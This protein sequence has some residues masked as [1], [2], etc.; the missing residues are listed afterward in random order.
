MSDI[1][2]V[3]IDR[4]SRTPVTE[5]DRVSADAGGLPIYRVLGTSDGRL[6]LRDEETGRDHLMPSAAF[7]WKAERRTVRKAPGTV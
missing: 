2:W 6:W 4:T 1:D 7:R 3:L 5:G